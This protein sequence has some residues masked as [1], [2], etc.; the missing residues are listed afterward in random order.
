MKAILTAFTA[1]AL[2]LLASASEANADPIVIQQILGGGFNQKVTITNEADALVHKIGITFDTGGSIEMPALSMNPIFAGDFTI[3]AS[4]DQ[5][6]IEWSGRGLA[7]HDQI[8]ITFTTDIPFITFV[9]GAWIVGVEP[10]VVEIPIDPIRDQLVI[11]QLPEP[12][13]LLLLA[14]GLAGVALRRR[15]RTGVR[16]INT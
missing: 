2:C 15:R 8:M 11:Q 12:A 14:T 3:S 16:S 13:T 7:P 9:R 4:G 1:A 10:N 6:F 5:I